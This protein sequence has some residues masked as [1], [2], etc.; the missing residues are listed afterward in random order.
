MKE[1]SVKENGIESDDSF[2][3][4]YPGV[5]PFFAFCHVN[6]QKKL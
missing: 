6:F 1:D 4:L 3:D 5:L 2:S